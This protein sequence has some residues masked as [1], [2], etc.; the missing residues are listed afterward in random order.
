MVP[1][2]NFQW[3]LSLCLLLIILLLL[4]NCHFIM[5]WSYILNFC[6]MS[7]LL[8]R[9]EDCTF[10]RKSHGALWVGIIGEDVCGFLR[11]VLAILTLTCKYLCFS[12]I[13]QGD[14]NFLFPLKTRWQRGSCIDVDEIPATS[15]LHLSCWNYWR[16]GI[17][18]F[19]M[20]L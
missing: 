12:L 3:R 9:S 10:S 1:H 16:W 13:M 20:V 17:K 6:I 14:N 4:Y 11:E 7:P 5:Q 18:K 2:F 19:G 8:L 15:S